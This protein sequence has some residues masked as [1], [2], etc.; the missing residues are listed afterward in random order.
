MTELRMDSF[1][2]ELEAKY[3][4]NPYHNST[5]AA[6]VMC[7]FVYL[8]QS[9][10]I[11]EHI[12]SL[13]LLACIIAALAHDVGHP[14]KN[15]RFL[16]LSRNEIAVLYNDI[17]VLEMMHASLLFQL[18]KDKECDILQELGPEKWGVFRKDV[19]DMILATDMGKH[20][21]LLGQFKVKY[22]STDLHDLSNGEVRLDL[23]KLMVKAA[24]IGHAAKNT[25]LHEMWCEL[26]IQEFYEQGDME[27]SLGLPL[28]MYC[29][30]E[31][32]DVSKS[33]VGFIKNIVFPL[34]NSLN[35]VLS[36]QKIEE[37][38]VQQLG[39]NQT[40]WDNKKKSMRGQSFILKK[41]SSGRSSLLPRT[42]VRKNSLPEIHLV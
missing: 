28:S 39:I 23:F 24:D 29:D 31:T 25:E 1:F 12:T 11:M 19:I 18:L 3:E 36:S 41:D 33:Q 42:A 35:L 37:K 34:F 20:F 8:L 30:R 5:H 32:T 40:F 2:K 14:G 4:K 17:S 15:N 9:S 16:V 10:M 21:E 22:L 13:E 6:D 7:S 26:V 38:C 27:K